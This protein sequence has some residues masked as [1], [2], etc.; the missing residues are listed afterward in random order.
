MKIN[1]CTLIVVASL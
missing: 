1:V